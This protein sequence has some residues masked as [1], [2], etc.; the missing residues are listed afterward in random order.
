MHHPAEL[1]GPRPDGDPEA[2]RGWAGS[3]RAIGRTIHDAGDSARQSVHVATFVGP[4]GD[5]TRARADQLGSRTARLAGELRHLADAVDRTAD[6]V[7]QEQDMW[8]R[9]Y[10][11]ELAE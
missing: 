4:A 8:Q 6:R 2:L 3:V 7:E 1:P 5:D 11:R 9:R 10:E